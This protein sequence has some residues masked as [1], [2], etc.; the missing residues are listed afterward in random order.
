[1]DDSNGVVISS[2]PISQDTKTQWGILRRCPFKYEHLIGII[3]AL[4]EE[5]KKAQSIEEHKEGAAEPEDDG[6]SLR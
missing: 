4:E 5:Q 3:E 2:T 1:M 6:S